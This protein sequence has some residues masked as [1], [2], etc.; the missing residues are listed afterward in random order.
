MGLITFTNTRLLSDAANDF[1]K[2]GGVYCKAPKGSKDYVEYWTEQKRRC[3][4][5]YSVGDIRITG[6]HYFYL[7]FCP[8]KRTADRDG[9]EKA[10]WNVI[11]SKELLFPAFW[12]VDYNWW[13]AKEI[14]MFGML[15]E[16]VAKL[17]I[18]ALPVKDYTTGKHMGCLKTRRAGFSYKEAADGVWNYNFVPK[19]KS[20][21][22]AAKSDY[23][24]VDGILN[25]VTDYLNHLNMNT[26]GYWRK[27]R[28]SG[29]DTLEYRK[30]SYIDK[31]KDVRGYQSEIIG[32]IINDPEKVRGKDGLKITY[33]EAGS[34]K[35]LKKALAISIPSVT[36]GA[37]LTGQV[38]IFGCVCAGTEVYK[39]NGEKVLIENLKQSD[40]ILG[41]NGRGIS[42][43]PIVWMQPP[44]EKECVEITLETGLKLRCSVDHPILV[45]MNSWKATKQY[46]R[47]VAFVPSEHLNSNYMVAVI[48]S[49]PVFGTKK[50]DAAYTLGYL[51]GD[52]YYGGTMEVIVDNNNSLSRIKSEV[53]KIELKRK[54][55][56]GADSYS[57]GGNVRQIV[58][59][60]GMWG[61]SKQAKRFPIDWK[62]YNKESLAALLGG[63]FDADGNVKCIGDKGISIIYSSTVLELLE[64]LKEAL[65]KFGIHGNICKELSKGGYTEQHVI[66]RL[67][68][69]RARSVEN[70]RNNIPVL[71][72]KKAIPV[73][74]KRVC[75]ILDEGKYH[76]N[77][78]LGEDYDGKL[79]TNAIFYKIKSVV[80]IGK[81]TIYN[82]NAGTTHSYL[83]NNIITHNTGGEEGED[84]EGLEEIF[85]EPDAYDILAFDNIWEEGMEGTQC[86]YFVPCT[87]ANQSFMDEHGNVDKVAALA[88]DEEKRDQKRKLKDPKAIDRRIAEFPR[89]PSEALQR[90]TGNFMPVDEAK[91]QL[92]RI[93]KN[94]ELLSSILHGKLTQGKKGIKF[95][96]SSEVHEIHQFPHKNDDDLTGCVTIY[97]A[98]EQNLDGRVP[99][100]KY[101]TVIDPYYKDEATDR[102]SLWAAYVMKHKFRGD[103]YGDIIVAKYVAR[104]A[105][106]STAHYN[107][108][109]LARLYNSKIQCE[110]AGGGQG[111]F[112]FL[113]TN[114]LLHLAEYEPQIFSV[115][116][117]GI[118]QKN[119]NY[120][121]NI[122]TD[123]KK[124]G[125]SYFAD[126][127]LEPRGL[128][129][130][131]E[132]V[133]NIHMI[134]DVSLLREIIKFNPD[135]KKNFDRISAMILAMYMRKE[136]EGFQQ[137]EEKPKSE[138][139]GRKG[140]G[141]K[142]LSSS[143]YSD[144]CSLDSL[145]SA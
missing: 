74:S 78:P 28:M 67:Y 100:G 37:Q 18:E 136:F 141:A 99:P 57:I 65:L 90:V 86:G 117:N 131:G 35:N 132:P 92:K 60:N 143:S 122:S 80:S 32:V 12:E 53:N 72:P 29:G 109:L 64:T 107:T 91:A 42:Q 101:Y 30:A 45:T 145:L 82:L 134:N 105:R 127:L 118:N 130:H 129:E 62:D 138:F 58:K 26:S 46:A 144:Y 13:W 81:Q 95:E 27:N 142:Q 126:W 124:N 41:Y 108:T 120:F 119:R 112:D 93:E 22:F 116:E 66:Y 14:A 83:A 39:A 102:T 38:S 25:K 110:I 23:L 125:L 7:N 89:T 139:W 94:Q 21:Y 52:G 20:Y 106:L 75:Q 137:Q 97:H 15:K 2:N 5:G 55:Q 1:K 19:S 133:L 34:F 9:T 87:M 113:R 71:N 61:Q 6:K 128:N 79:L 40:G 36:D 31:N 4:E 73:Q 54:H 84:I 49:V 98:P 63:Y 96:P 56:S 3:K 114:K 111:L 48:E 123:E 16:G 121:M 11:K 59:F 68:I 17:K 8:I 70:F 43:E 88:F 140:F 103:P 115:K 50:V 44:A 85:S 10:G 135:P 24:Y 51:L 47:K 76:A 104:P 69:G 77:K 33:E